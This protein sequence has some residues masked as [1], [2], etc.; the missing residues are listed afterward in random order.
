MFAFRVVTS[1][2]FS[3]RLSTTF[4]SNATS[5]KPLK[6]HILR[7]RAST[8][9]I[10][11]GNSVRPSV[12]T[13]YQFK[14]PY[15]SLESL[16]FHDKISCHSVK[17]VSTNMYVKLGPTFDIQHSTFAKIAHTKKS[18]FVRHDRPH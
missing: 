16:V 12:T 1:S 2:G 8:G 9:R 15:D 14:T 4:L 11:Y 5:H 6:C 7:A 10:S 13:Q 17:K 3:L 18:K